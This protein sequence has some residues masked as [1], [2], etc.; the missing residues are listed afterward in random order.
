[1]TSLRPLSVCVLAAV[2]AAWPGL[3]FD[4]TAPAQ[5]LPFRPPIVV[6][7]PPVPSGPPAPAPEGDLIERLNRGN[8]RPLGETRIV[9]LA[10]NRQDFLKR[11][12]DSAYGPRSAG[13]GEARD[14]FSRGALPD[15][16]TGRKP[17]D[18]PPRDDRR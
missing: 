17:V 4:G 13:P 3:S 11:H 5:D 12:G 2:M 16:E 10:P 1:M 8:P 14:R 18:E 6:P 7:L 9:P 15:P